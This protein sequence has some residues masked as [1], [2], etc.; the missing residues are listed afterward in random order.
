MARPGHRVPRLR[1]RG[2]LPLLPDAA[3]GDGR[4]RSL[5][6]SGHP[7]CSTRVPPHGPALMR[8]ITLALLV[9]GPRFQTKVAE[10][11]RNPAKCPIMN[12][13]ICSRT[14]PVARS[15]P[16]VG[17]TAAGELSAD[18]VVIF[19]ARR[20]TAARRVVMSGVSGLPFRR[21]WR[22]F[23]PGIGGFVACYFP[24]QHPLP[25]MH[26]MRSPP[27]SKPPA[28][29]AESGTPAARIQVPTPQRFTRNTEE[30]P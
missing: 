7:R 22:T 23:T 3:R 8:Q 4:Q 27:S 19:H 24:L 11:Y 9:A 13:A 18:S 16:G 1:S 30:H 15:R 2:G 25:R 5:G 29:C 20:R 17:S 10:F 14:L 6:M 12:W 26:G 21:R 28:D